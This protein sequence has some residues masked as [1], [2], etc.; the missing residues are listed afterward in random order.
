[1]PFRL[2]KNHEFARVFRQGKRRPGKYLNLH[3]RKNGLPHNRVGYTTLKHY[4]TAVERNRMRR[5]LREAYRTLDPRLSSGYDIILMG[6]RKGPYLNYQL[7]LS[8][9]EKVFRKEK[10]LKESE[11]EAKR[12]K[13]AD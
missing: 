8:D 12:E 9:M 10:I 2:K 13:T 4:G 11:T 1:M 5:L 3:Y 6:V 7:V